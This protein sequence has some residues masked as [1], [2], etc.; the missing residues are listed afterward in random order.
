ME[1]KRSD[2]QTAVSLI[3]IAAALCGRAALSHVISL[4]LRSFLPPRLR[5]IYVEGT[6]D[7]AAR[8]PRKGRPTGFRVRIGR[9][10]ARC[11]RLFP[12]I[13]PSG[14]AEGHATVAN[15]RSVY[16]ER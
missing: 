5:R 12:P 13:N 9:P 1:A 16:D 15:D 7:S 4:V 10:A 6:R 11:I 3:C 14:F 8:G 2:V